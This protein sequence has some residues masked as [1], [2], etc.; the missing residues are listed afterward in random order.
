MTGIAHGL[1]EI[2]KIA[3]G[4]VEI[5]K[6]SK[7]DVQVWPPPIEAGSQEFGS[8]QDWIVPDGVTS[9]D[10]CVIAGGGGGTR[11]SNNPRGSGGG[12]GGL[13][14]ICLL[15]TSPSPRDH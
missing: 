7:G 13:A 6:V 3:R 9:I 11:R 14:W 15:Y 12:G 4:G 5:L 2:A 1:T 8:T 10:I